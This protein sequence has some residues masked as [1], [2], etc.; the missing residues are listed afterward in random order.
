[1]GLKDMFVKRKTLHRVA[2]RRRGDPLR[3]NLLKL[4]ATQWFFEALSVR[5]ILH[6]V[7]R[8]G[9]ENHRGKN[10]VQLSGSRLSSV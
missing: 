1:M 3:K 6:R 7:N 4:C 8:E 2:R 5:K 9:V 10:S